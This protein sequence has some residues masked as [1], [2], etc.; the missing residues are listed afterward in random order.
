[1]SEGGQGPEVNVQAPVVLPEPPTP[2]QPSTEPPVAVSDQKPLLQVVEGEKNLQAPDLQGF[3]ELMGEAKI[4]KELENQ[5]QMLVQ[6]K[7]TDGTEI[8]DE[9]E[10]EKEFS[11][12]RKALQQSGELTVQQKER[13]TAM[14][15]AFYSG[16]QIIEAMS[17]AISK[18]NDENISPEE[19]K[20]ALQTLQE[21]KGEKVKDSEKVKNGFR[22]FLNWKFMGI[23]MLA[24]MGLTIFRAFKS[25]RGRQ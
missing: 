16:D 12:F 17:Q 1:M 22:Q 3:V 24:L 5:Y 4:P 18:L 6:G 14:E 13:L 25:L 8:R 23:G 10:Y 20:K 2:T 7:K 19:K 15:K 9:Q 11:S 21:L